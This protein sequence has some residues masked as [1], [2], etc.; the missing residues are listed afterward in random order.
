MSKEKHG[1]AVSPEFSIIIAL[2]STQDGERIL[3]ILDSLRNQQ[4]LHRYEVLVA[5]RHQNDISTRI[6]AD[7]PEVSRIPCA[8]GMSLPEL[9]TIALDHA[10][11][12]YIVV[13]ED[14]CVPT[15]NW[16]TGILQAFKEAPVNTAAVGGC[17]ENGVCDTA[18]DWAT[19]LCEYDSFVEP[20]NEGV[21]TVLPG[22]N[23][24]YHHS[25]FESLDKALLTS[26]FWETT[27]HPV[28]IEKGLKLYSSNKI[29]LYHC[30]KFSF[31]L[32]VQQRFLYSRYYAGQRFTQTQILQRI[33]ACA[34]SLL[35]PA[36]LLYRS[37]KRIQSKKRLRSAFRSAVPLLIVFYIVWACGEMVGYILGKGTALARIE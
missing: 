15:D 31:G 36:L 13:T 22:M 12:T 5:D 10:S 27:V 17:V 7:Y 20:V 35:L 19:F 2:V 29:R 8:Q 28:L 6:D 18:L 34:A 11:G 14:H 30:K 24:A 1:N 3:E 23:V 9:H 4:G 26:G 32:F 21:T 37:F 16:L 33:L 25:V